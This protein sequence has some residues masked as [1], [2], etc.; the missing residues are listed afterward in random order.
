LRQAIHRYTAPERFYLS[1]IGIFAGLAVLLAAVGLYGVVAYLVSGR[2]REFGIRMALGARRPQ[3]TTL[4]L[5]EA[6]RPT[7]WGLGLGLVAALLGTRVLASLLFRVKPADPLILGAVT[8]LVAAVAMAAGVLPARRA[9]RIDPSE[10]L[11]RE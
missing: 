6:V 9:T 4:V 7:V 8:A 2:A 10:A 1:T 3:I 11:R 5:R